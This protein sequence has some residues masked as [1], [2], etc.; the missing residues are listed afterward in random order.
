MKISVKVT[1]LKEIE[2]VLKKLPRSL[3]EKVVK[4]AHIQ[5]AKPLIEK[6]KSNAPKDDGDLIAS[7]G[8][9]SRIKGKEKLV[10]APLGSI[11]VG[12][13]RGKGKNQKGRHAHLVEYGTVTRKQKNGKVTGV[14]PAQPFMKP[15]WESTKDQI[16]ENIR[17]ELGKSLVRTMK[18]TIRKGKK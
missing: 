3:T 11:G 9:T 18:R 10:K 2:E 8:I 1:G 13:R 15:A 4:S 17:E 12:P 14:M 7:I 5:A 16:R 6:A